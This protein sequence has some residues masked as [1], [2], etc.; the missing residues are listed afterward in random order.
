MNEPK[1]PEERI[2][3]LKDKIADCKDYLSSDFCQNC[4]DMYKKI[5]EY[6][7]EVRVLEKEFNLEG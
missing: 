1:S 3:R 4:V 6:E 2:K 5:N 7:A